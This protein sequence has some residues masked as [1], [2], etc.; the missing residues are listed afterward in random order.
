MS[1]YLAV[2]P[3]ALTL[4]TRGPVMLSLSCHGFVPFYAINDDPLLLDIRMG[5]SRVPEGL[6]RTYYDCTVL[7]CT[8]YVLYVQP[9]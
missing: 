3:W 5:S 7:Y 2:Y 8:V 9:G 4:A 6:G 1:K